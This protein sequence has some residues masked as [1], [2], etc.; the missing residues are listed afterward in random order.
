MIGAPRCGKSSITNYIS[1]EYQN[2][3]P[4]RGDPSIISMRDVNMR[5][6][7]EHIIDLSKISP[8]KKEIIIFLKSL[9][10]QLKIDLAPIGRKIIMD[11]H[12]LEVADAVKHFSSDCDIYCL[13][14]PNESTKN[15]ERVLIETGSKHDWTSHIGYYRLEIVC[16]SI[17]Q[18]SKKM[19]LECEKYN[20]R[21]FDMSGNRAEKIKEAIEEIKKNSI[22]C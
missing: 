19:K 5:K 13:G 14:M 11:T 7:R 20:I 1:E 9:Y 2:Y 4:L 16:N 18:Q 12:S 8:T 6:C 17:I 15:L 21:F 22:E 10:E 3:E